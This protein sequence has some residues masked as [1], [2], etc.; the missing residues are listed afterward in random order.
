[1]A[2]RG[3]NPGQ[4][5]ASLATGGSPEGKLVAY[6]RERLHMSRHPDQLGFEWLDTSLDEAKAPSPARPRKKAS[7]PAIELSEE[8]MAEA[9]E[10]SGRYKILRKLAPVLN[11]PPAPAGSELVRLAI[12]DTETTGLSHQADDVIEL[13]VVVVDVDPL[14]GQPAGPVKTFDQLQDPG[15]PLSQEVSQ[16][17]GLTDADLKGQ[18]IDEGA[19]REVM[20]GVQGVIAHNAAFDRPFVEALF[21]D[22]F[23]PLPWACSVNDID[24]K[25][26]GNGSAKLEA[27]AADCGLFY[28]AHRAEVDCHALLEVL[29]RTST[30]GTMSKLWQSCQSTHCRLSAVGAPFESKDLLKARGYRWDAQAR[31]WSVR[32]G[33]S[34]GLRAEREWLAEHVYDNRKAPV[35]IEFQSAKDR[36]TQREGEVVVEPLMGA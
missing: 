29:A 7:K 13:A 36:F 18:A 27:L 20:Q 25:A 14:R 31:V 6:E 9:L 33:S 2:R 35:R 3:A 30:S 11:W 24:W 17:T 22:I 5:A 8:Q 16:L 1:V 12:L 15:R 19:L 21:P 23:K 34:D 32:L 26:L 4:G 10:A 28:D